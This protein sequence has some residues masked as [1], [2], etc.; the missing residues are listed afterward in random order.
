MNFPTIAAGADLQAAMEKLNLK[1][2]QLAVASKID[3]ASLNRFLRH[4]KPLSPPELQK[5]QEVI[6]ACFS[7]QQFTTVGVDGAEFQIPIEWGRLFL[8]PAWNTSLLARAHH[9]AEGLLVSSVS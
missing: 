8:K 7:I 6:A 4:G 2:I 3:A 1:Q 5:V 9:S